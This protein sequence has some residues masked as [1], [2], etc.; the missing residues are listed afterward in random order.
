MNNNQARYAALLLKT[1]RKQKGWS[2]ESV[3]KGICAVSYYS[4]IESGNV[5]PARSILKDL[6][7]ALEMELPEFE[8]E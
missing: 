4:K 2:Q 3:C 5:I 6:A 8:T 1:R 7:D